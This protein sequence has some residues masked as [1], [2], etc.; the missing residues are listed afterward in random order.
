[1]RKLISILSLAALGTFAQADALSP[2]TGLYGQH[3]PQGS[4]VV[5]FIYSPLG[6]WKSI[7]NLKYK[8]NYYFIYQIDSNTPVPLI[9]YTEIGGN[10]EYN[11]VANPYNFNALLSYAEGNQNHHTSLDAN[12]N[13]LF[14]SNENGV[15]DECTPCVGSAFIEHPGVITINGVFNQNKFDLNMANPNNGFY[16]FWLDDNYLA[17]FMSVA[18]NK[19]SPSGLHDDGDTFIRWKIMGLDS[20]GYATRSGSAVDIKVLNAMY[21][22]AQGNAQAAYDIFESIIDT[23]NTGYNS[24]NQRYEYSITN[25][26][27]P[28]V[29]ILVDHLLQD[30][31]IGA[32]EKVFLLQ[33][34]ISLRSFILSNLLEYNGMPITIGDKVVNTEHSALTAMSLA[35]RAKYIWEVGIP[36]MSSNSSGNYFFRSHNVLSAAIEGGSIPGHINYG[37]YKSLPLGSYEVSFAIRAPQ[38]QGRPLPLASIEIYSATQDKIL[39]RDTIYESDLEGNNWKE[40]TL[41]Y[42][43]LSVNNDLEFRVW[44]EGQVNMDLAYVKVK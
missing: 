26:H 13:L 31:Q 4:D 41:N 32:T 35:T 37:P 10:R 11:P 38:S 14:D 3:Y 33:H 5:D 44:W 28:M 19:P 43:E 27:L 18:Y 6:T 20:A 7:N 9:E 29:K 8:Y 30:S 40:F 23:I 2:V 25:Y 24:S 16:Q 15:L 1:M 21:D 34:S 36:P 39:A 17:R 22:L 12:G 42:Q